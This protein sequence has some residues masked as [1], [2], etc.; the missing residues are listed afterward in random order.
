MFQIIQMRL[1]GLCRMLTRVVLG[2]VNNSFLIEFIKISSELS[3][4][5]QQDF[6]SFCFVY[7]KY[8]F[9]SHYPVPFVKDLQYFLAFYFYLTFFFLSY[10]MHIEQSRIDVRWDNTLS[11]LL[12]VCPFC[13]SNSLQGVNH[14]RFLKKL[15]RV[16][17]IF[18]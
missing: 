9:G 8:F 16:L 3:F 13:F 2:P 1:A 11:R 14:L 12:Y 4:C 7:T 5:Q 10:Y 17:K 6:F 18:W 15:K